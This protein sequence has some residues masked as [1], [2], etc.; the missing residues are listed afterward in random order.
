MADPPPQ[1]KRATWRRMTLGEAAERS[2][3][4]VV[5]QQGVRVL[6]RARAA[7]PRGAERDRS[8]GA[9]R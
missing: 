6:A 7:I 1:D 5:Q 9:E 4:R 3:R 8:G 2:D